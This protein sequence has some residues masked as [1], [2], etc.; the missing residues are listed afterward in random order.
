MGLDCLCVD[1][2]CIDWT[3]YV[4]DICVMKKDTWFLLIG[5][6]IIIQGGIIGGLFYNPYSCSASCIGCSSIWEMFSD[7]WST[8]YFLF[9]FLMGIGFCVK[10]AKT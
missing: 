8:Y 6:I 5:V 3:Y 9:S 4:G 1:N 10:W 7:S 2:S